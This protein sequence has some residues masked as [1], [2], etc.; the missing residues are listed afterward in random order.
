MYNF[1][2]LKTNFYHLTIKINRRKTLFNL[3]PN[4]S[5]F[6][7]NYL[8][9]PHILIFSPALSYSKFG[10]I[11]RTKEVRSKSYYYLCFFLSFLGIFETFYLTFSKLNS[12]SI[13]C[14]N[15]NCSIVL[16]SVFSYFLNIP[17]STFGFV[18]YFLVGIQFLKTLIRF[19]N[20]NTKHVN[21]QMIIYILSL[22]LDFFSFYFIYIL[23]NILKTSCPWCVFS[24]FLSGLLLIITTL[25]GAGDKNFRVRSFLVFSSFT[26]III[27]TVN[28]LNIIE[29]QNF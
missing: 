3:H 6:K 25:I 19:P 20:D 4:Y 8:V 1:I 15:Q 27:L 28:A 10:E 7:K 24:I 26:C 12:S 5:I 2:N 16:S 29:L 18:L 23:E 13:L 17:L 14:S 11:I 22:F 9:R 21:S